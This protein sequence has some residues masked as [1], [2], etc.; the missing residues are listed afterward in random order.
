MINPFH[1]KKKKGDEQLKTNTQQDKLYER[2]GEE[3][4]P[5]KRRIE[6]IR[7]V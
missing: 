6:L 5:G 4:W 2:D 7:E 1:K 3:N